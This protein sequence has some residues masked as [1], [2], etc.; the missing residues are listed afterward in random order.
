MKT[1]TP[2]L[3]PEGGC[4]A[5]HDGDLIPNEYDTRTLTQIK[6]EFTK[7]GDPLW[8]WVQGPRGNVKLDDVVRPRAP[9]KAQA[10]VNGNFRFLP[11]LTAKILTV[12]KAGEWV[13][14]TG[15]TRIVSNALWRKAVHG[16][17][18]GWMSDSVL[19][20]IAHHPDFTHKYMWY[21]ERTD[22]SDLDTVGSM[23]HAVLQDPRGWQRAG[24]QSC[25]PAIRPRHQRLCG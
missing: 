17:H 10:L 7:Q 25:R 15:P 3:V 1:K 2:Q 18:V 22:V 20:N 24:S 12:V 5:V 4:L 9:G 13:G 6:P 11:S 14:L 16:P 19:G 21:L 23:I 8:H